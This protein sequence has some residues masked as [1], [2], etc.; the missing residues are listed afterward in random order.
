MNTIER[1][2]KAYKNGTGCRLS[3]EDVQEVADE[4]GVSSKYYGPIREEDW[5][6]TKYVEVTDGIVYGHFYTGAKQILYSYSPESCE[7]YVKEGSWKRIK[8]P[9]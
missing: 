7:A 8:R 4:L 2:T 5:P 1:L 6:V 9:L 3:R